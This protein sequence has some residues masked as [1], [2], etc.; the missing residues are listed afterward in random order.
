MSLG[1]AC[2][3]RRISV[4][5]FSAAGNTSAFAGYVRSGEEVF[6]GCG[7]FRFSIRAIYYAALYIKAVF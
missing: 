3:R 4:C 1:V 7:G 6:C 2:E 5:H